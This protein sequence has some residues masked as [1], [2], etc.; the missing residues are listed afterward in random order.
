MAGA[1][2]GPSP[3]KG[4]KLLSRQD[5]RLVLA[6]EAPFPLGSL[7]PAQALVQL[8]P[9]YPHW[10]SADGLWRPDGTGAVPANVPSITAVTALFCNSLLPQDFW[11]PAQGW[12][13]KRPLGMS[14]ELRSGP[15][16]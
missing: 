14:A 16:I 5:S 15:V 11:S 6:Q 3:L 2:L 12:A 10:E 8:S 13:Q 7:L 1:V 9:G 4:P